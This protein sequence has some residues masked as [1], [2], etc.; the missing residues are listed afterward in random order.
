MHHFVWNVDPVLI[1]FGPFHVHWYGLLFA[2]AI[3]LGLEFMKWVFR[4]EGKDEK[5]LEPL[6][7]YAVVG[8]VIGARLGHVLFYD[9]D[10]YF[11]HPMKYL[12]C[13]RVDL[14]LTAVVWVCLSLYI[15]DVKS[16]K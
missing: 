12:P 1:S 16:I 2:A 10:Y 7:L 11:A 4:L 3:L 14:L 8:I 6:F 9:P 13:G 5:A 15:M